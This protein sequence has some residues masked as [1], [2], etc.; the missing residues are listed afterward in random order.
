MELTLTGA[1]GA[2]RSFDAVGA[3]WARLR[4]QSS[5]G[6]G[7]WEE[8][9]RGCGGLE[10]GMRDAAEKAEAGGG[11]VGGALEGGGGVPEERSPRRKRKVKK[12]CQKYGPGST[13]QQSP[14]EQRWTQLQERC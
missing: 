6:S 7:G 3:G 1:E 13:A 9:V 11:H 12:C 14:P 4:D 10:E 2:E 5:L 8:A